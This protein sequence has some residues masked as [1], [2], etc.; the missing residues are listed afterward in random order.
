MRAVT[1]VHGAATNM[2]VWGFGDVYCY[3]FTAEQSSILLVS[4][5]ENVIYRFYWSE[6]WPPCWSSNKHVSMRF[7]WC[8]IKLLQFHYRTIIQ[9]VGVLQWECNLQLVLIR[10]VTTLCWSSNK[11]V[12]MRLRWCCIQL[13][14][15][16]YF[17]TEQ[18]S[19]LLVSC[20]QAVCDQVQLTSINKS[21]VDAVTRE[22][23]EGD[24]IFHYYGVLLISIAFYSYSGYSKN[25]PSCLELECLM[26]WLLS[27]LQR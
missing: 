12:S 4:C 5:N 11:H 23:Y 16:N 18:P 20:N 26:L 7:R 17:T 3:S 24:C 2:W 15:Y 25:S 14:R 1:T 21:L 10:A 27:F 19:N 9:S 22:K 8:C 13:L 6:R